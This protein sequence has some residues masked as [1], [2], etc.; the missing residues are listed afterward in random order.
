MTPGP[1]GMGPMGGPPPG[2]RR[3]H[4]GPGGP[5]RPMGN[6]KGPERGPE[7]HPQLDLDDLE[8]QSEEMMTIHFLNRYNSFFEETSGGFLN[9]RH[10][11][12]LFECVRL[13]RTFPFT[14]KNSY[15][16][17]R[18]NTERAKEI[19]IIKNLENDF[20]DTTADL[21][22]KHLKLRYFTPVITKI[23]SIKENSGHIFFQVETEDGRQQFT[24]RNNSNA[25]IPF[26]ETRI[27]ITDVNNNRY[28]IPDTSKL[29]PK[30]LTKLDLFI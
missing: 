12:H 29:N 14:D 7:T 21:L 17:I 8:K 15:I 5:G 6:F 24:V 20:D 22:E 11:E 27:F 9:L 4:G 2:G 16:S 13:I 18:E 28:E 26:T 23:Y 1:M 19:G 30:E 3:P 10:E 25:I